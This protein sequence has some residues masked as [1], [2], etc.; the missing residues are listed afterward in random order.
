MIAE[1]TGAEAFVNTNAPEK[2]LRQVVK[3]ASAFYLLGYASTRNPADGKFHQIKVRVKRSGLDVRARKGYWAPTTSDMDRA[4]REA[5]AEPP[6]EVIAAF[7]VLSASRPERALDVWLGASP[8]A[9]R[10]TDMLLTWNPRPRPGAG[11]AR[12]TISIVANG[13]GGRQTL[14]A[15]LDAHRLAFKAAPGAL[16]IQMIVRD[17]EGQTLDEDSREMPVPDFAHAR[18]ALSSPAVIRARNPI[19]LRTLRADK[20]ATPFA[21]RE[22]TRTDRLFIR[23]GVH[24]ELARQAAVSARL[25]NRT[26]ASLLPLT[27]AAQDAPEGGYEIDLPLASVA[28]GDYLVEITAVAGDDRA[29]ELVPVRVVS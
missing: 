8:A 12:G 18:V 22:F 24:G 19:E 2:A 6:G 3:D 4:A 21:G 23:F 14:E 11:P 27:V 10:S 1:S 20:D 26:G 28:R 29:R 16:E 9:D 7:A 5:A 25:L 17:P 13:T 15:P